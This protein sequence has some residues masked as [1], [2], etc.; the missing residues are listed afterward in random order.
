[1]F[2]AAPVTPP[3]VNFLILLP[4]LPPLIPP[5]L[6]L[7]HVVPVASVEDSLV[8]AVGQLLAAAGLWDPSTLSFA[9]GSWLAPQPPTV[10]LSAAADPRSPAEVAAEPEGA[11]GTEGH[12]AAF[13]AIPAAESPKES[14]Q[15]SEPGGSCPGARC[16]AV[17][18]EIGCSDG[19]NVGAS[20][21]PVPSNASVLESLPGVGSA[22]LS[23]Q[24]LGGALAAGLV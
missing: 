20:Y 21:H 8:A 6:V 16:G 1:M 10:D 3:G 9:V 24:Q 18:S 13:P 19:V 5:W 14:F 17:L 11:A 22:G 15:Q 2:A 12:P 4:P 23:P 7:T